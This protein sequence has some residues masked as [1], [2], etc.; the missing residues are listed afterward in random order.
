MNIIQRKTVIQTLSQKMKELNSDMFEVNRAVRINESACDQIDKA[1]R[2]LYEA[3]CLWDSLADNGTIIRCANTI[4]SYMQNGFYY[5]RKETLLSVETESKYDTGTVS[6][7]MQILESTGIIGRR[8][9]NGTDTVYLMEKYHIN[10][11][12]I[13]EDSEGIRA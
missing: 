10:I 2:T 7:A 8:T 12:D 9:I 5:D 4:L 6:R 1:R 3:N 13:I 11:V